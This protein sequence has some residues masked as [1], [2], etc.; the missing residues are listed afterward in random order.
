MKLIDLNSAKKHNLVDYVPFNLV[1]CNQLSLR[2]PNSTRVLCVTLIGV[3]VI[4][5]IVFW[6]KNDLNSLSQ[7]HVCKH[8]LFFWWNRMETGGKNNL[9]SVV[10]SIF[11]KELDWTF[12]YFKYPTEKSLFRCRWANFSSGD[13]PHAGNAACLHPWSSDL[14]S[15]IGRVIP[16]SLIEFIHTWCLLL[17]V[18]RK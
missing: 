6:I 16:S 4:I 13:R 8:F 18:D 14:P 1:E 3:I 10:H 9:L 7:R 12:R 11:L 5:Y 2:V 17:V 15:A